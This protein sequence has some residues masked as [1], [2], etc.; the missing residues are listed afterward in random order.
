MWRDNPATT[1]VIGW[2]QVSGLRPVLRYDVQDHGTNARAYPHTARPV[3]VPAKGMNNHFARLTGLRPNTVYYFVIEDSEGVSRCL[4]FQTA[5]S[6]PD[7]RLSIIAG[8]DSRNNREARIKANKL[9]SKLRPHLIMFGG[10]MTAADTPTEWID[11]M[12]DWQQTIGSDGRLFPIL[13]TRGNHESENSTLTQLFDVSSPDLYYAHTFGGNLLRVYTLNTLLP[14]GGTQ[15]DWL[16]KD[17]NTHKHIRWRIAQYHHTIRPHTVTKPERDELLL[18][19]ATLFHKYK[20]QL[21]VESDAHVVKWTYPIKPSRAPGS[22]MGFIRDDSDGTVYIG[23]G[24]WGAPLRENNDDKIWTRNSGSFNQFKWIFVSSYRLEIR[25]VVVDG[26]DQVQEVN[27]NNIFT[28]PRGLVLWQPSNGA[29]VSIDSKSPPPKLPAAKLTSGP[30]LEVIAGKALHNSKDII[31][32]WAVR[33]DRPGVQYEVQRS[34]DGG[35]QF[36]TVADFRA[37]GEGGQQYSCT[38]WGALDHYDV[39]RLRYQIKSVDPGG[40]VLTWPISTEQPGAPA[41]S[42]STELP[43]L[44]SLKIDASGKLP[45]TYRL[46]TAGKL[47]LI[48]TT[49]ELKEVARLAFEREPVGAGRKVI[50]L[51]RVP[52]GS[53]MLLVKGN[54]QLLERFRVAK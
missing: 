41:R 29:V 52:A 36:T 45:I 23:E 44:K 30:A 34:T 32:S 5:P 40:Q 22:E 54:D 42:S 35:R 31:V 43:P 51:S 9:V 46:T 38:D 17:L 50:D 2:D 18:N 33:H 8:G 14:S 4:S 53:Y 25:T 24:C 39:G 6:R 15:R 1:M 10:D 19:W 37:K 21:V 13:V 49:L 16:E 11:W 3:S 26:S 20:V 28:P 27:H 47:E 7:A 48:L 12:N